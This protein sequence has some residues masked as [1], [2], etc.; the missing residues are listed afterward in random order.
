MNGKQADVLVLGGGAIG[1]ACA[2]TLLEAGRSD[3]T[4]LDQGRV[5]RRQL[6]RQLRH[7]D[8]ENH[9]MPLAQPGT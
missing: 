2:L 9:A 6:A 8:A 1:L 7:A 5:G 4:V 3:V